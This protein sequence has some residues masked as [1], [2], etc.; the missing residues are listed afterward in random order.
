MNLQL[1]T[2][3]NCLD[4]QVSKGLQ[5]LDEARNIKELQ[6]DCDEIPQDEQ[7]SDEGPDQLQ[8]VAR[9]QHA[10]LEDAGVLQ[11]IPHAQ[12]AATRVVGDAIIS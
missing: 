12:G 7:T 1:S 2:G 8:P 5:K 6:R 11:D 3:P 4:V 10:T 9:S